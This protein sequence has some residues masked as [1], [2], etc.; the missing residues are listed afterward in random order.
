MLVDEC[1]DDFLPLYEG[2]RGAN[3]GDKQRLPLRM[4]ADAGDLLPDA[5]G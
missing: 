5:L 4:S 2:A 3:R 1:T